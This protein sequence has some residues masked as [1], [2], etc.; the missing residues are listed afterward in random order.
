M[1]LT[2]GKRLKITTGRDIN[3][4]LFALLALISR[5]II[6]LISMSFVFFHF[7]FRDLL[8]NQEW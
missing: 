4:V 6:L 1:T 5:T 8:D 2:R 3:L 7:I